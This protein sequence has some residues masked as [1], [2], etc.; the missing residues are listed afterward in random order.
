ML[1]DVDGKVNV[2]VSLYQEVGRGADKYLAFPISYSHIRTRTKR[3]FL[4]WVKEVR[5]KKS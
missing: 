2:F 5:T 4:G 3:I 1:S